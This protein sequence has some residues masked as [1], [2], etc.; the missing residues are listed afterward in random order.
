MCCILVQFFIFLLSKF[1]KIYLIPHYLPDSLFCWVELNKTE[2]QIN[3]FVLFFFRTWWRVYPCPTTQQ[4]AQRLLHMARP[5]AKNTVNSW[6]IMVIQ[7]AWDHFCRSV[8]FHRE[9]DIEHRQ[10]PEK[11]SK[12]RIYPWKWNHPEDRCACSISFRNIRY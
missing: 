5:S 6:R 7:V 12:H 10:R 3:C 8:A 2:F 1:N 4:F 9:R 11:A